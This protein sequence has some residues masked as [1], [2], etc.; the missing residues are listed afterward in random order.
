MRIPESAVSV[1][2]RGIAFGGEF[3]TNRMSEGQ[4]DNARRLPERSLSALAGPWQQEAMRLAQAP[5]VIAANGGLGHFRSLGKTT[6]KSIGSLVSQEVFD[7]DTNLASFVEHAPE[8]FSTFDVVASALRSVPFVGMAVGTIVS[9]ARIVTKALKHRVPWPPQLEMDPDNDAAEVDEALRILRSGGDWTPLF[10]PPPRGPENVEQGGWEMSQEEGGFRFGRGGGEGVGFGC[11]PGDLFFVAKGVQSR[12]ST[13]DVTIPND[14]RTPR[15]SLILRKGENPAALRERVFSIGEWYPG[16]AALGRSVWS[17]VGTDHSATMFQVD[18]YA[19]IAAWSEYHHSTSRFRD[20]MDRWLGEELSNGSKRWK[21]EMI[22]GY[23]SNVGAAFHDVRTADG[24]PLA[25]A[26]L[27]ELALDANQRPIAETVGMQATRA[28][29]NLVMR[30]H[31]KSKT[32]LNA[33]VSKNAP[34]LLGDKALREHFLKERA[35]LL[36]AGAFDGVELDEVPDK[37]LR[38]RLSARLRANPEGP[39][40]SPGLLGG[41]SSFVD[42]ASAERKRRQAADVEWD[43]GP[44]PPPMTG[45]GVPTEPEATRG[46]GGVL[47]ATLVAAAGLGG[48]AFVL[49]RRKRL[50]GSRR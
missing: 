36:E 35:A 12:I 30:Q 42:P 11:A 9:V 15:R 21:R 25:Q 10:L 41:V 34:A 13:G 6:L 24:R 8:L 29:S 4:L 27:L 22:A 38:S 26:D 20:A 19:L 40:V 33:L 17:M 48:T 14:S 44:R 18:G 2:T 47:A 28:A 3:F 49:E 1:P 37:G 50:A 5:H 46:S 31:G 45:F 39:A 32:R 23:L 43:T 16:L 7:E